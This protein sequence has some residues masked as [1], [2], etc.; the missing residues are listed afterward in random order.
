MRSIRV[1]GFA[2][3]GDLPDRG[4]P[5]GTG[6]IPDSSGKTQHPALQDRCK[7]LRITDLTTLRHFLSM[8]FP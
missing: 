5:A 7:T 3:F 1:W 8:H 6:A 2:V 4:Q